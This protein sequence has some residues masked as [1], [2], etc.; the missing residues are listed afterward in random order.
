MIVGAHTI[1]YSTN[2]DADRAFFRDV[3]RFTH[4]DAGD[5]WLIFGLPPAEVAFHPADVNDIHELYLLCE[6]IEA[7]IAMLRER[8]VRCDPVEVRAWGSVTKI[9][10]PG[11]G[12][13]GA[14]QPRHARP[15][16]AGARRRN[17][18]QK[19][20]SRKPTGRKPRAR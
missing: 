1:I 17:S 12:K 11:G 4:V 20:N 16:I 7:L 19:R 9:A 2:P 3:L 8:G 15:T 14:Y 18:T 13:L 6:D 5:G 10:L